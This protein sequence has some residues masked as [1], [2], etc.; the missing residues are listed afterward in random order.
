MRVIQILVGS[1]GQWCVCCEAALRSVCSV[2]GD[3][4]CG[5]GPDTGGNMTGEVALASREQ[6]YQDTTPA[7]ALGQTDDTTPAGHV[8]IEYCSS[9]V[10]AAMNY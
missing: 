4:M 7:P 3:V 10:S 1:S 6:L 9:T 5:P 2:S 8:L